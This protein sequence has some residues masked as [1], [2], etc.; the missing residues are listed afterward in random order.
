MIAV[1][2]LIGRFGGVGKNE[3]DITKS[4]LHDET[5]CSRAKLF[6]I[7]RQKI[8]KGLLYGFEDHYHNCF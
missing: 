6:D 1:I 4:E 5:H 8:G 7:I 2:A 3:T